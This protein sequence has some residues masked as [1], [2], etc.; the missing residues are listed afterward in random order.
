V[1]TIESLLLID[2]DD[3]F[4]SVTARALTRLGVKVEV[5]P[6]S[7]T[8]LVKLVTHHFDAVV[9]D[10]KL[11]AENGLSLI[12]AIKQ[13]KPNARLVLLTGYASIA[14]AVEAI[15]RGADDYLPK[16]IDAPQLLQLLRGDK[17]PDEDELLADDEPSL[18]RLRWEHV[19]RVL[20]DHEFNVSE[21]ARVLGVHRRTLQRWLAKRPVRR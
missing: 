21:S 6:D 16:P 1:R 7:A 12:E 9:L 3:V 4:R 10:L 14:T 8:A 18:R 11:G 19:Q 15:K 20:A 2:D 17:K 13:R 5:A